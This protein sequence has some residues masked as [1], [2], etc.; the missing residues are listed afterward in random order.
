[1]TELVDVVDLKSAAFA[2]GFKSRHRHFKNLKYLING[3][4]AERSNA[5]IC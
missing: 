4:M 3:Q 2:C 5:E 1:M